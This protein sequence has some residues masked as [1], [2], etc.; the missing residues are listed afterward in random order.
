[1]SFD[2]VLENDSIL[3]FP[4]TIQPGDT[5]PLADNMVYD[6]ETHRLYDP[7][8]E[9]TENDYEYRWS[10][11]RWVSHVDLN[12]RKRLDDTFVQVPGDEMTGGLQMG[13]DIYA[14]T[15]PV[16]YAKRYDLEALPWMTYDD[17]TVVKGHTLR[18]KEYVLNNRVTVDTN[19]SVIHVK[20]PS[21]ETKWYKI[22]L[23]PTFKDTI[24]GIPDELQ[25]QPIRPTEAEWATVTTPFATGT[26]IVLSPD[27]IEGNSWIRTIQT[28]SETSNEVNP[29]P[30][31][32]TSICDTPFINYQTND[33][34]PGP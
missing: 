14:D 25:C 31:P 10:Q 22:K 3:V 27:S 13:E 19:A 1:M 9:S 23:T 6:P 2:F 11:E 32:A 21:Y 29:K 26:T 15:V 18:C 24:D 5:V 17:L 8:E 30:T 33:T 20:E 28:V 34:I 12:F 16:F 4:D 7:H